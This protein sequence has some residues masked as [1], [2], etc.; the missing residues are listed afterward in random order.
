MGK[1]TIRRGERRKGRG[2]KKGGEGFLCGGGGN[3]V[4]GASRPPP[5][6]P[7]GGEPLALLVWALHPTPAAPKE[8]GQK[9]MSPE[10]D[11][12]GRGERGRVEGLRGGGGQ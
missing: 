10:G 9:K 3:T 1:E 4:C 5:R 11:E 2:R 8:R 6:F 7:R 12:R